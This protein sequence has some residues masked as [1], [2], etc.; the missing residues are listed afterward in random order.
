M[1]NNLD[2]RWKQRF[3]NHE[4][5]VGQLQR[6]IDKGKLNEFEE[7]GLIQCFE[8]TYELGWNVLKDYLESVGNQNING[9]KIAIM[10]AFRLGIIEDGAGWMNM[11]K[12]RNKSSYTYNEDTANEIVSHIYEYALPLFIALKINFDSL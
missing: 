4:K 6:F 8:Y 10:T 9:S 5:A 12:D 7:Q 1:E 11:L 2:I 3:A